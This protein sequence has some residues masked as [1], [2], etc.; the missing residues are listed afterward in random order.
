VYVAVLITDGQ[1]PAGDLGVHAVGAA[2]S[3]SSSQPS[4]ASLQASSLPILTDF[5]LNEELRNS[6]FY[7]VSAAPPGPAAVELLMQ[8][9]DGVD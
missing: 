9:V 4:A 1:A 3:K 6:Q 8:G 7:V 2:I 5:G